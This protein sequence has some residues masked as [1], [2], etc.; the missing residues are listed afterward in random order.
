MPRPR[1]AT[2]LKTLGKACAD[3]REAAPEEGVLGVAPRFVAAPA[4]VE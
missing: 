2:V 4:T 3:V 1:A